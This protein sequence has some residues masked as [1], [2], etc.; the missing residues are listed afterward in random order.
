MSITRRPSLRRL[1][2][3]FV[4]IT[5]LSVLLGGT[6]PAV[7]QELPAPTVASD[8]GDYAPGELVTLTGANWQPGE[9]VHIQ[10]NDDQGQ[11]WRRDVDVAADAE[12]RI[13]DSFNL[14]DWFVALYTVTATGPLSG[15]A[16][17][18]FTDASLRIFRGPTGNPPGITFTVTYQT[19]SDNT[20][21]DDP[22]TP[23]EAT[24]NSDDGTNLGGL[25]GGQGGFVKL[26]A[27]ETPTSPA[28]YTFDT[29]SSVTG[30]DNSI[31]TTS[32]LSICVRNPAGSQDDRY[33]ATYKVANTAPTISDIS[34]KTTNEDTATGAIAFTVGDAQ[35]A[36][37]DLTV[38]GT[39]SNTALVPNGN[40]A[41]G[42]S[43]ANRTVTITPAANKHGTTTITIT[44]SDGSLSASDT[45]VLTVTSVNDAPSGTDNTITIDED[46]THT[47]AASHFGFSDPDDS[48]ANNLAA[49][50]ITTVPASGSLKLDGTAVTTGQEVSKLDID[51]GD[52]RYTP[53]ANA[54]GSPYASFTF[55]VKDD[56]GTANGG[57]NLDPTANT[58]TFNVTSVNDAPTCEDVSIIT[59]ENT[60]G[61][62]APNC[63]DVE[64]D[65]LTYTAN[66][67]TTGVSGFTGGYLTYDPNGSFESLDTGESDTDSFTYSA[68]DGAVDSA[69]GTVNVTINGANDAPVAANDAGSTSEDASLTVAA[70][71]VLGNDTD[72][73]VEPLQVAQVN[74][75]AANVGTQITLTSGA[76]V[77]LNANGSFTYDPNGSFESLD[78]GESTTDSFTYK[79]SDGDALSNLATVT[80]TINGANDAPVI[81]SATFNAPGG[82]SCPPT[83]GADNVT[84]SVSFFDPDAGETHTAAV[85]WDNNPATSGD[86]ESIGTVTSPFSEGHSYSTPGTHTAGITVSDGTES[87]S[88]TAT[89]TVNLNTSGILQPVNWTQAQNDPSVFKYGSTI[90]VKVRFTN[91]DGT[92]ASSLSVSIQ[93]VKIAGS[94]PP[95]GVNENITN[96]NSP[97]SGGYMRW[98]GT[99]YLYNL[100]TRSLSDSTATYKITLTVLSTGQTVTTNFGTRAK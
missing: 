28:G 79:A 67:A 59:N 88:A 21:T 3:V 14:P 8:K 70:P 38:S 96:T 53:A 73:D 97:D 94:T 64:G 74:G 29:W 32:S 62:V 18:T 15:T 12:G 81:T 25:G 41:F 51:A 58:I 2:G 5:T 69:S 35:T 19:F 49:V 76:K 48:P 23:Q 7:A 39:S 34:D 6:L 30:S 57:Q 77:T 99:Q 13:G 4:L 71:G 63:A 10:V 60:P 55:Q 72:V 90:P 45:F 20:C 80:I 50:K 47:F 68:N 78:T 65:A 87:A 66:A 85:D 54:S 27:P 44:V 61:S 46:A 84:L 1:Q 31:T 98:D 26:T 95:D 9:A 82:V 17:T 43:G 11:S 56:G 36:A 89:V 92:L 93:V 22:R 52:L 100:N 91:C 16:S 40:I 86:N 24:V 33:R 83:A 75:L 42:G 37:A